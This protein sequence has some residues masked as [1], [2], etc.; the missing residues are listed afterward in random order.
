MVAQ[1][2]FIRPVVASDGFSYEA[3]AIKQWLTSHATSPLTNERLDPNILVPNH[4][5]KQAIQRLYGVR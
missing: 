1:E 4:T 2:M 3:D 5:L